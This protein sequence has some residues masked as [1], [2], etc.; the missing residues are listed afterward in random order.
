MKLK[1][2]AALLTGAMSIAAIPG[3]AAA[4]EAPKPL[5]G[6][7]SAV[8]APVSANKGPYTPPRRADGHVDLTGNWTN[9]TL[10]P[11]ERP[12]R[13]GDRL[14]LTPQE[15]AELEGANNSLIELGNRPTP[16]SATVK[17]LPADCSGGR[18]TNC[19][20]NAAW[21]DPGQTVMRV[22]GQPRSALLTTPNGRTPPV[23]AGARAAAGRAAAGQGPGEGEG[24][25]QTA[26]ARNAESA[27]NENPEGRGLGERCIL[28]FGR[29]AGPPM[30]DQLY[31]ST[32]QFVQTK[33]HLAIVAEMVHDTRIVKIG[34]THRTDGV[35]PWFGDSIGRWDGDV[36]V[37]E[38]TNI[39][40]QQAYKGS[41]ENLKVTE[42][43]SRVAGDRL[44]YQ[45]T[46]E[47]PTMWDAPW[48]GEYEFAPAGLV[49]E[50]ACHEGNYGLQNILAGARA[51]D[52]LA[53]RS[54]GT[55]TRPG[56]Q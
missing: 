22:G 1:L 53:V 29:S 2:A 46:I 21:T 55:N 28:S 11:E 14:V 54:P 45:F 56:T 13:Y 37:V 6:V 44:R 23:K 49:Y 15:T 27:R 32:Y 25:P 41:W 18:V 35:R 20:Y 39:P 36:L 30:F 47:D 9:S 50:Y 48:G 52:Q 38:T 10:T 7:S 3:L 8:Q 51:E 26:A 33:D 16:A 19:N 43:F 24:A 42:R 34:G 4:Q 31:N 40:R 12:A 17:D 5:L